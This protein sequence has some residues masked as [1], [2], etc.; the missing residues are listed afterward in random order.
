MV[1]EH[2][3]YAGLDWAKLLAKQLPAPIK[4]QVKSA[5]DT[6]NFDPYPESTEKPDM[7]VYEDGV[8]PFKE[9]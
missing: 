1:K 4:P 5:T 3:F 6:S 9:F 8:D 7:P 2:K